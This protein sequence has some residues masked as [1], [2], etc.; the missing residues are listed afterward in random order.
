MS[1]KPREIWLK[2]TCP[3]YEKDGQVEAECVSLV[4]WTLLPDGYRLK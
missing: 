2:W 3:V 4:K 1:Q